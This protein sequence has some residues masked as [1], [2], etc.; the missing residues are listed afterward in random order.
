MGKCI[1]DFGVRTETVKLL[2]KTGN[3]LLDIHLGNDF[4]IMISKDQVTK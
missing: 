4:L 1:R 2:E 3:K